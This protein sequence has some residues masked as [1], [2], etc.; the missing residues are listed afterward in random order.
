MIGRS[1]KWIYRHIKE[2]RFARRIGPRDY[3]FSLLGLRKW[4]A[5]Q[6]V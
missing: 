4:Q 6:K 3:S 2:L 5:R 1:P